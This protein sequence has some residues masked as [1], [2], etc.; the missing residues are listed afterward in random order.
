MANY[1]I[2]G[3][4]RIGRSFWRAVEALDVPTHFRIPVGQFEAEG[5]GFCVHSVRAANLRRVLELPRP[6]LQHIEVSPIT[7][8][9]RRMVRGLEFDVCEMAFTTYLCAKAAG[10][11]RMYNQA[12]IDMLQPGDVLVAISG[13]G[14]SPNVLR[15]V[16]Y[17]NSIGVHT[18][19]LSGR[20]AG[21]TDRRQLV[22]RGRRLPGHD[23]QG[24]GEVGQRVDGD[25]GAGQVREIAPE[26]RGSAAVGRA[27]VPAVVNEA[28]VIELIVGGPGPDRREPPGQR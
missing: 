28:T 24:R 3:F 17:A 5:D 11:P 9:M 4:G 22:R 21:R 19:A 2:N 27:E 8:A 15:A 1:A 6:A 26:R 23:G 18:I 10:I 25:R 14:N 7:A 12:A 16:E 13:S 20:D